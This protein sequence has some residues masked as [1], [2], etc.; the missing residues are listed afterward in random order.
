MVGAIVMIVML[1]T[2]LC[3]IAYTLATYALP[4]M[5]AL[6]TA[7]FAC[8]TGA[9]FIGAGLAALVA[10]A[11]SFGI[12]ALLF[13]TMRSDSSYR[14]RRH[15]CYSCRG[16]RLCPRARRGR[17]TRAISDLAANL[18]RCRSNRHRAF[19]TC[20]TCRARIRPSR[21]TSRTGNHVGRRMAWA[22]P[23]G[24]GCRLALKPRF[25]GFHPSGIHP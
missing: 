5:L 6:A 25:A 21:I 2:M 7:R 18:L 16:S 19:S 17:R 14:H 8:D 15:L 10:G 9:G 1:I 24:P 3:V 13:A 12:L 23:F 4:F 11:A 22:S 20:A